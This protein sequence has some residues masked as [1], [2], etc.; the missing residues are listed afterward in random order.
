MSTGKKGDSREAI[1]HAALRVI[2]RLGYADASVGSIAKEAGVNNVT[3]YRLFEGKENL[4]REVIER[5]AEVEFDEKGLD[6]G[7]DACGSS[8]AVLTELAAAH[9]ET[10]F[11]NKDILRIFIVE[12]P[13]FDFVKRRSWYM[14]PAMVRHCR[15]RIGRLGDARGLESDRLDRLTEMFVS[16]IVRRAMEYNKHDSIWQFSDDLAADFRKG[17]IP[18]VRLLL[19]LLRGA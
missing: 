11:H 14:P 1:L 19:V 8:E 5:Y 10:V 9:F 7:L 17:M 13:H 3:V 2:S 18:Q 16:H 12:A 6:S 4:F 15:R